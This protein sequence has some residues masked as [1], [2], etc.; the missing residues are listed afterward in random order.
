MI[1]T[2]EAG[3]GAGKTTMAKNIAKN[4]R[5]L[6]ID[7][8]SLKNPFWTNKITTN[9]EMLIVDDVEDIHEAK[10]LFS[11]KYL[12]VQRIGKEPFNMPMPVVVLVRFKY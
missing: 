7:G 4:Y 5:H 10:R 2:I 12:T 9:I 1:I 8:F 6:K 11:T 3:A